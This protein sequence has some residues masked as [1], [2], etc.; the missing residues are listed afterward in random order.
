MNYFLVNNDFHVID[1]LEHINRD[2]LTNVHFIIV[3][4]R[5]NAE[6]ISRLVALGITY[7]IFPTPF[8]GRL[9]AFNLLLMLRI[10]IGIDKIVKKLSP[11][12]RLIFYTEYELIN[13][14][15][16]KAFNQTN[17]QTVLVEE[18][19]I[20]TYALN[21]IV[22]SKGRFCLS[23]K[24]S[25]SLCTGRLVFRLFKSKMFMINKARFLRIE[26][27]YISCMV[28]YRC[29][30]HKRNIK[31][32]Y[33]SAPSKHMSDLRSNKTKNK[34]GLLFLNSDVYD[35]YMSKEEYFRYMKVLF[36]KLHDKYEK[37]F[38]KFHP[39]EN[40]LNFRKELLSLIG[41]VEVIDSKAPAERVVDDLN[42]A[43][44]GSFLSSS[45]LRLRERGYNIEFYAHYWSGFCDNELFKL[46]Y[47]SL[48]EIECSS[49][50]ENK[51]LSVALW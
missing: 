7:S 11:E 10:K 39:K 33:I 3:N 4:H 51:T 48:D 18:A 15:V 46:M 27:K 9:N 38:F 34:N 24:H 40:D 1:A 5:V 20:A 31:T 17:C 26:D 2:D 25:L 43:V 49:E 14:Y 47:D 41:H 22:P 42:V 13:H 50:E 6:S 45:L 35:F 37:I 16:C 21:K 29:V 32:L 12:D 44:V 28:Y 8:Q 19:G 23:L 30:T 36:I